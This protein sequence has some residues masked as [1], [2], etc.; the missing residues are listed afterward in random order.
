MPICNET[1]LYSNDVLKVML[2]MR[3]NGQ[4]ERFSQVQFAHYHDITC[5]HFEDGLSEFLWPVIQEVHL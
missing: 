4:L 5:I 1:C 3:E 2:Q